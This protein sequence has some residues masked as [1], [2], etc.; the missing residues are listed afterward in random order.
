MSLSSEVIA[1]FSS[2]RLKEWTNPDAP[3]GTTYDATRLGY[4]CTDAQADFEIFAGV[5]FDVSDARHVATAIMGV[6]AYL[7]CYLDQGAGTKAL[8]DWHSGKLKSLGRVTGRD[9]ILP[10]TGSNLTPSPVPRIPG[11][12]ARPDFDDSVFDGQAL[13]PPAQ[14]GG[15]SWDDEWDD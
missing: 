10:A 6:R 12:T 7:L 2:Q 5:T 15:P 4:A 9:R 8:D 3:E 11:S 14:S 1:R 13:Q